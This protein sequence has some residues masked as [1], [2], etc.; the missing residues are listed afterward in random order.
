MS[1]ARGPGEHDAS[2]TAQGICRTA[3]NPRAQR[4]PARRA[5]EKNGVAV[6]D[7]VIDDHLDL[8]VTRRGP[9]QPQ[10]FRSDHEQ[11]I[12]ARSTWF[13]RD[14]HPADADELDAIGC[15]GIGPTSEKITLADK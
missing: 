3:C 1:V 7:D 5:D 12:C 4:M 10:P 13:L 2:A 11:D 6:I 14:A 8:V 9:L 15:L